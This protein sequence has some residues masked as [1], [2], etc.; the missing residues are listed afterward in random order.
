MHRACVGSGE[1]MSGRVT[2][3]RITCSREISQIRG[4]RWGASS[5]SG[6]ASSG[7]T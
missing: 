3:D 4:L 6:G 7:G 5:G 2:S 1:V